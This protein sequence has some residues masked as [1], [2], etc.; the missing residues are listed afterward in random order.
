MHCHG[1]TG[2][3]NGPTAQYLNPLPRDYRLG[4]FKFKSTKPAEK[5]RSEDL[6]RVI[7]YGIPGTYM[8]SFLLLEDE[9][10]HAIVEY[11]R[12]LSMRGETEYKVDKELELDYSRTAMDERKEGGETR[13]ELQADVDETVAGLPELYYQT[14]GDVAESWILGEEEESLVM[15]AVARVPD[16]VES[17]ERGRRFFL[18]KCT[19]CHG[20]VGRGNGAMTQ[21]F[22]KND[23]TGEMY[24]EP[25]LFDIW[26]NPI[27]PRNLT[28]G[29]YR[30]GRRPIDVY[31]RL[32]GGIGPSKMPNFATTPPETLWDTVNYV[33]HIPF[34]SP[35]EYLAVDEAYE[36][37]KKEKGPEAEE[38]EK[39]AD[40]QQAPESNESPRQ[41]STESA[42]SVQQ[43]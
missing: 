29:Q 32:Y 21:D 4:Q 33:M 23:A 38:A 31:R 37:E 7:R 8:P 34:A 41:T 30:G 27:K 24:D 14:A 36:K 40:N 35:D 3:G 5:V 16:S 12:W 42:E 19:N 43:G 18:E 1:V 20:W 17:R 22:Q 10:M 6:A 11:V 39:T 13:E 25:G 26:G 2:D 9:E 15:P 28:R